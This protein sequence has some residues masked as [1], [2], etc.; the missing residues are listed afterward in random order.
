MKR[1][2]LCGRTWI[3]FLPDR[4]LVNDRAK[5]GALSRSLILVLI[6]RENRHKH[7]WSADRMGTNPGRCRYQSACQRV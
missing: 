3:L 1:V 5:S 2:R 4:V 7:W 6:S